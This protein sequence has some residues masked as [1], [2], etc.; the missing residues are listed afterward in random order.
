MTEGLFHIIDE[1][2]VVLRTKGGSYKQVAAYRRTKDGKTA[3]YASTGGSFVMLLGRGG[4][5]SPNLAW[6]ILHGVEYRD[7]YLGRPEPVDA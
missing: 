2:Q 3:I 5:S 1:A 6:E 7:G 4:T